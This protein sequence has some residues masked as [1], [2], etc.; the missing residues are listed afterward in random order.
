MDPI[1]YFQAIVLGLL[2]GFSELFPIS[3]LGHSVVL[4]SVL[5]WDIHQNDDYFVTFLVA[6][7]SRPRWCCSVF[8]FKDWVRIVRGLGRSLRDRE[9]GPTTRD[10][11]L[12]WLLVV[13][14]IPAGLLG[15]LLEHS[16][17]HAVRLTAD[18]PPIFLFLNG[19]ML[20]RRRAPAAPRA[21]S[22]GQGRHADVV[23]R[24]QPELSRGARRG[25]RAGTRAHPWAVALGRDDG[26]AA[27]SPGCP[28]RRPPGSPSCSRRRSSARP[29][30]SS[31]RTCSGSQGDG[32]RGQAL[33]GALC[34]A[35]TA[36][37]SVRFLL[38]F[39][40]TNRL[41]PFAIYCCAAGAVLSVVFALN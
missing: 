12:G 37:L 11:K 1:S 16:A 22:I 24:A 40:E 38:R 39:F 2:Q 20:L 13:G 31:C 8:F 14:T 4:P 10:A 30:C 17:A 33:V 34:A 36:Y 3:S 32:V 19:L 29:P 26:W 28:T 35:F 18:R 23:N 25:R 9:I 6:T 15:L 27:C 21:R 41:T 7:H 5:G